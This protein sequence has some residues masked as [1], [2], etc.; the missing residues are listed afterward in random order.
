ME[1]RAGVR[2]VLADNYV[3]Q[4]DGQWVIHNPDERQASYVPFFPPAL[5]PGRYR[6]H[7]AFTDPSLP[8]P[9]FTEDEDAIDYP[10]AIAEPPATR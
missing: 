5:A 10:P 6:I 9:L 7:V 8:A 1:L 3:E 2:Y 4:R